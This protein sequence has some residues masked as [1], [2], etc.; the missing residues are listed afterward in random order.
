MASS[1]ISGIGSGVDTVAIVKA[2]VD[3]EKAPK[4]KQI[5]AL[6]AATSTTLSAV[7]S[8]QSAL[9]AYRTA[10][11]AMN[12]PENYT[13]LAGSSSKDSVAKM[14]VSA[15]AS[16]GNYELHVDNLAT[17][18][19]I[20]SK[21]YTDGPSSVLNNGAEPSSLIIEQ[22]GKTHTVNILAGATLQET[23]DAINSQLSFTGISANLLTD[24]NG[25]RLILSSTVTG[26]GTDL[27]VKGDSGLEDGTTVVTT[28]QNASYTIDKISME[29]ST[30]TIAAAV[31]GVSIQLLG[32][33]DSTISVVSSDESL[34]TSVKGFVD[35]YN[36]LMTTIN[37]TTKITTAADGTTSGGGLTGDASVRSLV[38][39]IRNELVAPSG[40]G[41]MKTLSEFG[42]STNQKTG[43]LEFDDKKWAKAVVDNGSSLAGIMTGKEGLISRMSK[44][45]E[46]FA[47]SKTGVFATRSAA[48][49]QTLEDLTTQQ[50]TLESRM[51]SL[52]E[53]LTKKYT[54][55]DSLVA[56]LKAT[57]SSIMTTL[58]ALNKTNSD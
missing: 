8:V 55:M 40:A 28:P 50:A 15:G 7:G 42:I 27:V 4:Q 11:A 53:S 35:A 44:A 29:S 18:S 25:S 9:E 10:L 32:P 31:S 30:N 24:S 22:S 17:S 45:T 56:K 12:K 52:T 37:A 36:V 41:S 39:S 23:R 1:V 21:V 54:A 26:K 14:T 33:G 5:N 6:T 3:A 48:L 16:T 2:L 20:S 43:L 38:S 51:T 58:N 47:L 46:I 57:S 19:K 34:K 13:G 49:G